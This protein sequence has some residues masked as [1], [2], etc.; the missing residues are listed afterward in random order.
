MM[1]TNDDVEQR[2]MDQRDL[3]AN[4]YRHEQEKAL[5]LHA[6]NEKLRAEVN[7]LRATLRNCLTD[8]NFM[9]AAAAALKENANE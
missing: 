7:D 2:L 4:S 9:R 5:R 8:A 3:F 1:I 6:E